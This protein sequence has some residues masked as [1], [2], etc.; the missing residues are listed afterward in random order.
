MPSLVRIVVVLVSDAV[1]LLAL[2][3]TLSGFHLDS[4]WAVLAMAAVIGVLNAFVW[5]VL[6]RLTLPLSVLALG[7]FS[8]A[9]NALLVLLAA[10]VSPGVRLDGW[11]EVIVVTVGIALITALLA[12]DDDDAWYRKRRRPPGS[13]GRARDSVRP[14]PRGRSAGSTG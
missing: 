5:P 1:A 9:L 8:L 3:W 11:F 6:A 13:A 7:L 10:T 2:G 4:A 14:D 12:I